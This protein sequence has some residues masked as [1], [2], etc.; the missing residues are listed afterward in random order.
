[1]VSQ[2]EWMRR[3]MGRKTNRNHCALYVIVFQVSAIVCVIFLCLCLSN[4]H[5]ILLRNF[6]G[7]YPALGW[8]K[9]LW[10]PSCLLAVPPYETLISR[11]KVLCCTR[12]FLK[13][14]HCCFLNVGGNKQHYLNVWQS[15]SSR[16]L[17]GSH[18][19]WSNWNFIGSG[20]NR[21]NT[22]HPYISCHLLWRFIIRGMR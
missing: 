15:N 13:H 2:W 8:I 22:D 4:L 16:V 20:Y 14:I 9:I 1:M 5:S 12:H 17:G 21:C 18:P 3:K 7:L 11:E 19:F 6:K 10:H